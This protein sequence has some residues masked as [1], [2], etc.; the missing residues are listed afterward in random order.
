MCILDHW[1]VLNSELN[2]SAEREIEYFGF[3]FFSR[4]VETE[5]DIGGDVVT[6]SP[7]PLAFLGIGALEEGDK[8]LDEA[9]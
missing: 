9:F 5:G 3:L 6:Y 8:S 7:T 1:L 2:E 4:W